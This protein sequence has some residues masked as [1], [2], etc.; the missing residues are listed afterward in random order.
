MWML[1]IMFVCLC[2]SPTCVV[3]LAIT[4]P[5]VAGEPVVVT[6]WVTGR[7][8]VLKAAPKAPATQ[9]QMSTHM[10]MGH[11]TKNR[12]KKNTARPMASP[13]FTAEHK[14]IYTYTFC[15]QIL[16][17]KIEGDINI[18]ITKLWRDLLSIYPHLSTITQINWENRAV[19][20]TE[21][22]NVLSWRYSS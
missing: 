18:H 13:T 5:A 12:M 6:V 7:L 16:T 19:V 4:T 11:M 2:C 8:E 1:V 9:H 20:L 15:L 21:T 14:K 22:Y 17:Q 3:V 10:T